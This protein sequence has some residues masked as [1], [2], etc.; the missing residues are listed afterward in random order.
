MAFLIGITRKKKGK[1]KKEKV[2]GIELWVSVFRCSE[3]WEASLEAWL[4]ISFFKSLVF[5]V[6]AYDVI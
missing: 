4:E 6:C 2:V 1:K 3:F 5:S